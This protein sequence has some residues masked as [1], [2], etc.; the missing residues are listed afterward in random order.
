MQKQKQLSR[1]LKL[2]KKHGI[3][4]P[5]DLDVHGIPR[6]YLRQLYAMGELDRTGRG[7]YVLSNSDVTENHSFAQAAKRI[8]KGVISLLSALRFHE[9]TTQLP[10]EVWMMLEVKAWTPKVDNPRIRFMRASGKAFAEGIE[11]HHIEGIQVQIYNPA[12]TV[13]DCF[14]YR[15]KV[16]LDVAIEALRDCIKQRKA[17][18]DQLWKYA[19]I[20][21]VTNIIRPYMEAM[22]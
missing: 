7:M 12:K 4:R 14:K 2:V 16:G 6:E 10:F 17:T 1:V 8:P 19:V 22:V 18:M 13:A 11:T 3:L 20:C 21:R 9:L 5:R 15:N